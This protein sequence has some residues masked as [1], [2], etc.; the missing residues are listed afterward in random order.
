MTRS[1]GSLDRSR[2]PL[3]SMTR[4]VRGAR[5]DM[6]SPLHD[7]QLAN[8]RRHFFGKSAAGIGLAA[9]ATL[10]EGDRA[11]ADASTHEG[12]PGLPHFAPKARRV[13]YLFQSGGPSHMDLFDYKPRLHDLRGKE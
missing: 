7:Y 5:R 10:L 11:G 9:L 8:T 2:V 4:G 3:N 13:I 1:T 12:L 6:A